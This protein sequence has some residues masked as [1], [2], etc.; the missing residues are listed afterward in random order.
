[1]TLEIK[2]ETFVKGYLI[3]TVILLIAMF[4]GLY[5]N[6]AD[7]LKA[8]F[9][10]EVDKICHVMCYDLVK[11]ANTEGYDPEFL[12]MSEVKQACFESGDYAKGLGYC[13]KKFGTI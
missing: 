3:F 11:N 12:K 1:M 10:A 8:G 4:I 6:F 2:K 13:D 9:V 7:A 5:F